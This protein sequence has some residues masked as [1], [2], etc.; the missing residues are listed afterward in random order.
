MRL[1]KIL[2]VLIGIMVILNTGITSFAVD[3]QE[4]KIIFNSNDY[5]G[6]SVEETGKEKMRQAGHSDEFIKSLSE[7]AIKKVAASPYALHTTSYYHEEIGE[8]KNSYL[9]EISKDEFIKL[10]KRDPQEIADEYIKTTKVVNRYETVLNSK[11]LTR[12]IQ[13][14]GG[15]LMVKTTLYFVEDIIEG[16]Y[17]V[18]SEY[19]WTIPPKYRGTDYFGITRDINT[20]EMPNSFE[21]F[22][23]YKED[24]YK[25]SA[26]SSG[27][28]KTK[29]KPNEYK[30]K[31]IP[32]KNKTN[33]DYIIETKLPVDCLPP[34]ILMY[35]SKAVA[36]YYSDIRGGVCYQGALQSPTVTLQ[37]I[38]HWNYYIHQSKPNKKDVTL[39]VDR[40][41][42]IVVAPEDIFSDFIVDNIMYLWH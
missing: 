27:V 38:N 36:R 2:S 4:T 20:V 19:L 31:S 3:K 24:V 18:A 10:G 16:R 39:S 22:F 42:S 23:N 41:R 7:R 29:L 6:L 13:S 8:N 5:S 40:N 12:D 1:R 14:N 34:N 30:E 17:L 9:K 21:S 11:T 25:Y 37:N 32:E 33:A 35:G 15:T 26:T 28:I